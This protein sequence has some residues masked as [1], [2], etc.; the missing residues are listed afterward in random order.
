MLIKI[1]KK[2]FRP[3][4]INYLRGNPKKAYKVLNFKPEYDF[5]KL[6]KEMINHDLINAK[7]KKIILDN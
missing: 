7:K 4:D 2:Y 1:D 6:I 5:K 3:L